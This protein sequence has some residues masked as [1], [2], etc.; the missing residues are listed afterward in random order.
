MEY[1]VFICHASED[2]KEFVKPLADALF[3]QNL[4]VWYDE[5]ELTLGDS[6]REKIDYG[7]ANSTYGVVILSEAFFAKKWPKEELDGLAARQTSEGRKVILPVWHK[8]GFEDVKKF[9]PILAGKLAAKSEDG[10]EAVVAQILAVVKAEPPTQPRSV[11][12]TNDKESLRETCLELI[13]NGDLI[14]WRDLVDK[15]TNEIY[16]NLLSWKKTGEAAI[17]EVVRSAQTNWEPWQVAFLE[18]IKLSIPGLIPILTTIQIGKKDYYEESV[19]FLRNLAHLRDYMVGCT[20]LVIEIANP[21]LYISGA[22]GMALASR[23]KQL[24]FAVSWAT[25]AMPEFT[26]SGWIEKPWWQIYGINGWDRSSRSHNGE[27]YSFIVKLFEMDELKGF[28]DSPEQIRR[29]LF[30]G[31]FLLS[32]I[33][34]RNLASKPSYYDNL[35]QKHPN[36]KPLW[37]LMEPKDFTKETLRIF[38]S[39]TEVLNFAYPGI[40]PTTEKFWPLWQAWKKK[41]VQLWTSTGDQ[42]YWRYANNIYQLN[43]PGEPQMSA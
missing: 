16:D 14:G 19:V 13:R 39:S 33:E 30:F 41:C 8:V 18:A 15:H 4:N 1:D 6:L 11:F 17:S 42:R 23:T 22:I 28:F 20:D 21:I 27:P 26:Y 38:G 36:V 9:S 34:F 31:N 24:D 7:L 3:S 40:M 37:A 29:Y 5:F 35:N 2:K 43:L 12:Q 10:I 32:M 25:L